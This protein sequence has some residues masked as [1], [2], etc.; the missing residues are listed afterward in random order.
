MNKE[1]VLAMEAGSRLDAMVDKESFGGDGCIHELYCV[2]PDEHA[3]AKCHKQF[4]SPEPYSYSADISAAWQVVDKMFAEGYHWIIMTVYIYDK[5]PEY[6]VTVQEI[7]R[8][9]NST[10]CDVKAATVE[11]AICKAALLIK[12]KEGERNG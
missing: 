4:Y 7:A 6:K 2:D 8:F 11:E 3:C 9:K 10:D 5:K 12:I 1:E